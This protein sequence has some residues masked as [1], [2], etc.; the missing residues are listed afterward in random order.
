ME[1]TNKGLSD[2]TAKFTL[3]VLLTAIITTTSSVIAYAKEAEA[4]NSKT[5]VPPYSAQE[6]GDL[7]G[8]YQHENRRV[9][10]SPQNLGISKYFKFYNQ[11]ASLDLTDPE[12]EE[13]FRKFTDTRLS[14]K[15]L[16]KET[17]LV[18]E[19]RPEEVKEGGGAPLVDKEKEEA[20]KSQP[21]ERWKER[22]QERLK[23][24]KQK[25]VEENVRVKREL[26]RAE[27]QREAEEMAAAE[28]MVIAKEELKLAEEQRKAEELAQARKEKEKILDQENKHKEK[29][30]KRI[31]QEKERKRLLAEKKKQEEALLVTQNARKIEQ[32]TAI[33][34]LPSRPI[35]YHIASKDDSK[36]INF[37]QAITRRFKVAG[38]YLD[39][40]EY[41]DNVVRDN[42]GREYMNVIAFWDVLVEPQNNGENYYYGSI[43]FPLGSR[44]PAIIK[45]TV[46]GDE[47]AL[48]CKA[49]NVV[50]LKSFETEGIDYTHGL[51]DAYLSHSLIMPDG[52]IAFQEVVRQPS[53]AL[54]NVETGCMS[55]DMFSRSYVDPERMGHDKTLHALPIRE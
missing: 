46:Q 32:R 21:M 50:V 2:K 33:D 18:R 35:A 7:K 1:N 54:I 31:H 28:E 17:A 49:G 6:N 3:T 38:S 27:K 20:R 40:G 30:R 29:E 25:Q 23:A 15:E 55:S 48:G 19:N 34:I 10:L 9:S 39:K 51:I 36:I 41:G 42:R 37:D 44:H 43:Q 4:T 22:R 12:Q 24:D 47:I 14:K 53:F 5:I 8:K 13:T 16:D 45:S 52:G 26:R 11:A